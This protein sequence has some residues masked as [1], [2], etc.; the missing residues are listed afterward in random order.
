MTHYLLAVQLA[1]EMLPPDSMTGRAIGETMNFISGLVPPLPNPIDMI[2]ILTAP[3]PPNLPPEPLPIEK[4]LPF[5]YTPFMDEAIEVVNV[6]Q[7]EQLELTAILLEKANDRLA[8]LVKDEIE[9][10]RNRTIILREALENQAKRKSRY[11]NPEKYKN[12]IE[13]K[14]R[15]Q[16]KE[17]NDL[18]KIETV[19]EY[20]KIIID[21]PPV[22]QPQP[23]PQ[24]PPPAYVDL[25]EPRYNQELEIV[26]PPQQ[27]KIKKPKPITPQP[28]AP[29]SNAPPPPRV[30]QR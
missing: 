21:P 1:S 17:L 11:K 26:Q 30:R 8:K 7:N 24:N 10:Y 22:V 25:L 15:E 14:L 16:E 23:I 4:P 9:V 20:T 12:A 3:R 5:G 29:P 27:P 28:V 18:E 6:F 2:R 13:Q 19:I